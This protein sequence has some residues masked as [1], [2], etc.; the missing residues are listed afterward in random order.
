[1]IGERVFL[2]LSL[3]K[4]EEAALNDTNAHVPTMFLLFKRLRV[5]DRSA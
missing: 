2:M 1:M 3:S 5:L 4:H